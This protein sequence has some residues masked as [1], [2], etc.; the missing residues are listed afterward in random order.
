MHGWWEGRGVPT[1]LVHVSW[2]LLADTEGS[3]FC[4]LSP[5]ASRR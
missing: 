5:R 3:E 2:T 1:R 4:V